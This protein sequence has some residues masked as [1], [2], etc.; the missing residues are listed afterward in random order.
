MH[1]ISNPRDIVYKGIFET[2]YPIC[3]VNFR[4]KI[5]TSSWTWQKLWKLLTINFRN[6]YFY[7]SIDWLGLYLQVHIPSW[8]AKIL[9]FTIFRLLENAFVKLP[10]PYHDLII[11][12]PYRTVPN[13][14]TQNNLSPIW[15]EKPYSLHILWHYVIAPLENHVGIYLSIFARKCRIKLA[16]ILNLAKL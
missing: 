10:C 5:S 6:K 7:N 11:N 3:D 9:R 14:F 1:E 16:N 13:N 8:L 4:N 2:Q 12:P 15:H